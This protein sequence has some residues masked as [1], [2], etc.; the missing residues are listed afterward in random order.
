L[1]ETKEEETTVETTNTSAD[2]SLDVQSNEPSKALQLEAQNLAEISRQRTR[3]RFITQPVD[4]SPIFHINRHQKKPISPT[5]N[6][7]P[8]PVSEA[9]I[10][11]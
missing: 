6:F 7:N 2:E 9:Q 1:S 3:A 4:R 11:E 5:Y 8:A 10:K